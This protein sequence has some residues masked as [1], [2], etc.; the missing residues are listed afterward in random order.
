LI[1]LDGLNLTA[2][3]QFN[4]CTLLAGGSGYEAGN[5][6][7]VVTGGSGTGM[8]VG[9]GFGL[10]GQVVNV[11]VVDPGT[12]Y[13]DGD[14][15]TMSAGNG[16]ATF[17][18]TRY[19]SR[20]NQGNS[21]FIQSEWTF[22]DDGK[23]TLPSDSS[24][25]T[26]ETALNI[27]THSTA[28]YTFNQAYWEELN[29]NVTRMFT[30][31][32][33]AQ[34]FACTVTANQNGAYTVNITGNGG[35][36][37]VPGN[38]FKIPGN[39]LGG[40]TPANDI[41]ITVATV[42]GSGAILTTTITGSAVGKQW[43]F[44]Q[45]G[46]TTFPTGLVLGA[47]RG[48]N[49][50][51]FTSAIDKEFQ[52]ETQTAS[53]G[54]LWRFGT[55][56]KLSLP[57]VP[58]NYVPTT[59]TAVPV[60]YGATTLTFTVLLD[61]TITNM[62]VAQGAGGY[63][64]GS[65]ELTI[66]GTTFPGGTTPAND[67]VFDVTTFESAGPVFS[68]TTSSVVTYVLGTLPTRYNS[69]DS[70]GAVGIG[71]GGQHWTFGTNGTLTFPNNTQQTTAWTGAIPAPAN[72]DN[73][74]GSAWMTFYADGALQSTSKVTINPATS[75]LTINGNSGTG[76]ITFP[77]N[78]VQTTASVAGATGP[79][80]NVG[81][82]GSVGSFSGTTSSQIN[83]SNA[84][85]STSTTTGALVVAGGVGVGGTI[86]AGTS[87]V[88]DNVYGTV[89]TTQY[90][91]VFA[92]AVGANATSLMQIKG[93]DGTNGM[94]MKAQTGSNTLIYSNPAIEFKI[95]STI[96][97]NDVPTGGNIIATIASTGL[98][99]NGVV[100]ATA[101]TATITSTAASVGYMGVPQN[102]QSGNYTFVIGDAGKHIL[103][104]ASGNLIIPPNSSV[105]FPVGTTFD[106]VTYGGTTTTIAA[107][108]D[109]IILAGVGF[110]AGTRTLGGYGWATLIKI[111]P[112]AWIIRGEG[113]S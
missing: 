70:A 108:P 33:N 40:A 21:N 107:S 10:L 92:K 110:P 3:G 51:N 13:Q 60:T 59:F 16:A 34:Y 20:A 37:L 64:P 83:T 87:L 36:G 35:V 69:I 8:V 80:G 96:R 105:P 100:S 41:Q 24:I 30:P 112:T 84:T 50:V 68:T 82:T 28:T 85:V 91:S 17:V 19:N 89:T 71:A 111:E 94:G 14:V 106:I 27:A 38:W 75:M 113:L 104:T 31:S 102:S 58:W 23:L 49:T 6:T 101:A 93:N 44:G 48:V 62:S 63:G 46:N 61:N 78:T 74:S 103:M 25:L 2:G 98:T 66:P 88:V 109:F 97:D 54:K 42:N 81:Y 12:G 45:S 65:V 18:I 77:D 99:V 86:T 72:G 52:I 15:L 55:D 53:T 57:T 67:I 76:G 73:T 90:A 1:N 4:I 79:Q 56:G 39:Q 29:A 22:G 47:P 7:S 95:G 43:Q 9:Y 32:S 26:N 11:G 5:S